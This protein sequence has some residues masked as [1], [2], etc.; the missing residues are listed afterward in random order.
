MLRAAL[1]GGIA[2]GK[3]HVR[4]RFEKLGVGT[5][6]SDTLVHQA[7]GP[8]TNATSVI[9]RRFGNDVIAPDG[10]VDRPKL[11]ALVFAD[12][13]A[14]RDLEAVVHPLVYASI[15]EWFENRK[16]A[17]DLL[18]LADI[19]LLFET[20]R[21]KEFDTVIVAACSPDEQA[22][23]IMARDGLTL[24]AARQRIAAQM[25][26]D[27]KLKHADY[28]VWTTGTLE[29]TDRQIDRIHRQLREQLKQGQAPLRNQ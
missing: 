20:G 25:P 13:R 26:I 27:E 29:E 22:R 1:T 7:L 21:E 23:R 11:G 15:T 4:R 18:A 12:D 24:E 28:I 14:R 8:G 6:D 3:S 17:G 10:S 2:T 19:P 9:A 5:I 16:R